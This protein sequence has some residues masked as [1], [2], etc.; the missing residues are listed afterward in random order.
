MQPL[1]EQ[2]PRPPPEHGKFGAIDPKDHIGQEKVSQAPCPNIDKKRHDI[3][4]KMLLS[5]PDS[6]KE[7]TK[8]IT[9]PSRP[10]VDDL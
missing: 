9:C 8:Y 7:G 1:D 3:F 6:I 2:A 4:V 5:P 10:H